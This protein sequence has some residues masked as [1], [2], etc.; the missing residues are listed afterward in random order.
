MSA[1][2]FIIIR[3]EGKKWVGYHQFASA[4]DEQYDRPMFTETSLRKAIKRAQEEPTE[5]G[6]EVKGL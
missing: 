5:Y 1:D 4:D 3:Q 6:Y 2:N